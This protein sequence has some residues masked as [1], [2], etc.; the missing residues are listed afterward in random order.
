MM[1]LFFTSACTATDKKGED[2][3]LNIFNK[4]CA[5]P[6]GHVEVEIFDLIG[7]KQGRIGRFM[8]HQNKL[9][10]IE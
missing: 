7:Y 2:G 3:L 1:L 8:I 6:I 9:E 5:M 4:F 10:I